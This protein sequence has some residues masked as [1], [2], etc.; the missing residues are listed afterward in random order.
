[1]R[2]DRDVDARRCSGAPRPPATARCASTVDSAVDGIRERELRNR[3]DRGAAQVRP[4]L[5]AASDR[6]E[7]QAALTWTRLAWLAE[8]TELP[9]LLKGI[10]HPDDA[11]LAVEAGAA[12]VIVSNHGGRQLDP[13]A[14]DDRG[15]RPTSSRRSATASRCSSTAASSAAPTSSRRSRSAPARC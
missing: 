15:A 3:F 8:Q 7:L 11:G 2:G 9:L 10:T 4:N 14:G 12:A 1:M 6:R 5:G 13:P